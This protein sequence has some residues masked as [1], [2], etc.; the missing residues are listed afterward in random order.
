MSIERCFNCELNEDT[1]S[2][3]GEYHQTVEE[4]EIYVCESCTAHNERDEGDRQIA[5]AHR[6]ASL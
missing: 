3:M 1:D 5:R 6:K 4:G 2:N